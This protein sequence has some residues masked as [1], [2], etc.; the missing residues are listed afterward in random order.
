MRM[1]LSQSLMGLAGDKMLTTPQIREKLDPMFVNKL[2]VIF[3]QI[4]VNHNHMNIRISLLVSTLRGH[5]IEPVLLKGLGL[6]QY[7]PTPELRQCGDIDLY[8]REE[9]Y[10][11]AYD[12]IKPIVTSIDDKSGIWGWMHFDAKMDSIQVEVH[13]KA[14]YMRSSKGDRLYRKFMLEGLSENLPSMS[15]R[16]GDVSIPNPNFNAFYT[17]YHLWRHFSGSGVGLRQFCDWA[18]FLHAH[19]GKLDLDYLRNILESLGFMRPWQVLG[20]FL[21]KEVGLPEDEFPFYDKKYLKL[22]DKIRKYVLKDGNFGM[23]LGKNNEKK[24]KYFLDKLISFKFHLSRNCRMFRIFP[25]HACQVFWYVFKT[26]ISSIFK[27]LGK[28]K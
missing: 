9:D 22:S 12:A 21:V 19:A 11:K 14:D 8:V 18:C 17:F 27:D 23:N 20:A 16:E 2:R 28:R 1:A 4:V 3:K 26:G 6:A 15:L 24:G 7:Y 13:H 10:E 25:K 5:G